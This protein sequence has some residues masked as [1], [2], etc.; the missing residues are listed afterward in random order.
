MTKSCR[1][2]FALCLVF[3]AAAVHIAHAASWPTRPIHWIVPYPPGGGTDL[4]ARVIAAQL[5]A[6]G[7]VRIP[8]TLRLEQS[9]TVI[10]LDMNSNA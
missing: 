4:V 7:R 6:E 2:L 10:V 1:V 3:S 5:I 9:S 8:V